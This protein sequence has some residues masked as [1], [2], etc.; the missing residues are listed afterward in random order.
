MTASALRKEDIAGLPPAEIRDLIR[1]GLWTD[2]TEGLAEGYAQANLVILPQRDAFDFLLFCQRNPKPCPVIEV[3]DIGSPI[4]KSMASGA[5]LRTDLPKYCVYQQGERI[6]EVTDITD[7]WRDDLVGFLL[8]C[9]FSFTGAMQK[10]DIDLK[11]SSLYATNV[12][13]VPAGRFSGPLLV[14][15]RM[16]PPEDLLRVVQITSRFPFAHGAPMHIGDPCAMGIDDLGADLNDAQYHIDRGADDPMDVPV[17][18]A[19][20]CT[21]QSVALESK[22]DFMISHY[23]ACCFITDKKAE[24]ISIL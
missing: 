24:E 23:S 13:C 11:P 2:R 12:S 17:F 19:C 5:D 3:T 8:G 6:D 20:G 1:K 10:A 22:T 15:M 7:Y 4:L 16:V 14:T 18:W 21:P 9:S